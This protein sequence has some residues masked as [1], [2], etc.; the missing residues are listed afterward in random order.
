[1]QKCKPTKLC[2]WLRLFLWF[3]RYISTSLWPIPRVCIL[4]EQYF[5]NFSF[6]TQLGHHQGEG[7]IGYDIYQL[8]PYG[9]LSIHTHIPFFWIHTHVGKVKE[10]EFW[11]STRT[12]KTNTFWG[13]SLLVSQPR[14]FLWPKKIQGN[15][16]LGTI[17]SWPN[18]LP[19]KKK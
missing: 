18:F 8:N 4:K 10:A 3:G 14:K 9:I 6:K 5:P 17:S 7:K 2:S 12:F 16:I 19:Q 1:M 15:C 13:L 11:K